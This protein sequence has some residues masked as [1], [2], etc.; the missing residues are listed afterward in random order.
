MKHTIE[1]TDFD[2][3][4]IIDVETGRFSRIRD[5]SMVIIN[6]DQWKCLGASIVNNFGNEI[7]RLSVSELFER[8]RND[9]QSLFYKNGKAKFVILDLDHGTR[10]SWGKQFRHFEVWAGA[11]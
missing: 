11:R 10:R 1:L 2:S 4:E 7:E 3:T 6:S 8:L 5:G 9:K